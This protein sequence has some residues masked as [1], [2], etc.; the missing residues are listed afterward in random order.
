[1]ATR[2]N[3]RVQW[4]SAYLL[5][6]YH[7][8]GYEPA[9]QHALRSLDAMLEGGIYDQLGGGFARY[10]TDRDWLIPHFE[11][12]LYDNALIVSALCDAY[13]PD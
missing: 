10:A 7:F 5:E 4:L 6:H 8:T 3:S 2:R 9:L 1:L 12:M 11:K 13:Q